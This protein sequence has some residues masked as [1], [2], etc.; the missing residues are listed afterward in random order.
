MV[1]VIAVRHTTCDVSRILRA[2][3]LC[4]YVGV[5]TRV[6]QRVINRQNSDRPALNA[7]EKTLAP[8]VTTCADYCARS[9]AAR[10]CM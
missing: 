5:H 3:L 10:A 9:A 4:N 1:P 8:D 2:G 7:P 6:L